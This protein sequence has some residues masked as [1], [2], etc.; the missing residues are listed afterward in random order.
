MPAVKAAAIPAVKA[1]AAKPAAVKTVGAKPTAVETAT[2]KAVGLGST[3]ANRGGEGD[4]NDRNSHQELAG[5]VTLLSTFRI[6]LR[7]RMLDR[8]AGTRLACLVKKRCLACWNTV[9][10]LPVWNLIAAV[11]L[12]VLVI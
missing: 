10:L 12:Q 6:R 4:S 8:C 9:P 7:H 5:H 11:A 1:T 3:N 2:A